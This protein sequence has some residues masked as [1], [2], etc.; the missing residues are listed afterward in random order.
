MPFEEKTPENPNHDCDDAMG[1]AES[2]DDSDAPRVKHFGDEN[3]VDRMGQNVSR[4]G[5]EGNAT[6]PLLK[7]K[8]IFGKTSPQKIPI[9]AKSKESSQCTSSKMSTDICQRG[10][11]TLKRTVQATA[12]SGL[13]FTIFIIFVDVALVQYFLDGCAFHRLQMLCAFT[14]DAAPSVR[15]FES[16]LR[17]NDTIQANRICRLPRRVYV[18]YN[19]SRL[20]RLFLRA[21][22]IHIPTAV[23]AGSFAASMYLK[24]IG[25]RCS[26]RPNDIDIFVFAEKHMQHVMQLYVQLFVDTMGGRLLRVGAR[27]GSR[28]VQFGARRV[29]SEEEELSFQYTRFSSVAKGNQ[30]R[31]EC[32]RAIR[33]FLHEKDLRKLHV[34]SLLRNVELHLPQTFCQREYRIIDVEK[35]TLKGNAPTTNLPVNVI[36]VEPFNDVVDFKRFICESFDISLCSIAVERINDELQFTNFGGFN[37]AFADLR[38]KKLRLMSTSFAINAKGIHHQM[39]RVSKYLER[40]YSW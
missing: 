3:H 34:N 37:N 28:V 16:W 19:A 18:Q 2:S 5:R 13:F 14:A 33:A 20:L 23:I 26:W 24:S 21:V 4:A 30:T 38:M 39:N 15:T 32:S 11:N 1:L 29:R 12:N 9:V 40:G 7:K 35:M 31:M 17:C 27:R 22:T 6:P 25:V 8:R 36:V 10:T